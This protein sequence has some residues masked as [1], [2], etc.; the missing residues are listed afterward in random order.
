M[1]IGSCTSNFSKT[2]QLTNNLNKKQFMCSSFRNNNDN[3]KFNTQKIKFFKEDE[4]K[5]AKMSLQEQINYKIKLKNENRY[6]I[7]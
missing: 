6:T 4:E 5:M 1:N 3:L 7:I 2:P